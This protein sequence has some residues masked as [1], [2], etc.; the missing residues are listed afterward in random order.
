MPNSCGSMVCPGEIAKEGKDCVRLIAVPSRLCG[1]INRD[2]FVYSLG[3][4]Y[5]TA[6]LQSVA[7][8]EGSGRLESY[9][10]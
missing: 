4:W 8:R 9:V 7:L 3:N 2:D 10:V 6:R 5:F 1:M